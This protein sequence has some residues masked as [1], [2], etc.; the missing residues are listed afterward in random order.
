MGLE[1]IGLGRSI[2]RSTQRG[3][4]VRVRGRY[5]TGASEETG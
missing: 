1:M 2:L 3:F 5:T 4:E